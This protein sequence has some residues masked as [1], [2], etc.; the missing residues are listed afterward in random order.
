MSAY[1]KLHGIIHETTAPYCPETNGR[2]ERE[3]KTIKDAARAMLHTYNSP[4][5]LWAEAVAT[6]VYI[7]NRILN[8]MSP[9][10]TAYQRIFDKK[11]NLK[12]AHVFGCKAYLYIPKEQRRVWDM[13]GK[14]LTFVGYEGAKFKLFDPNTKKIIAARNVS[15]CEDGLEDYVKMSIGMRTTKSQVNNCQQESDSEE[16]PFDEL[17]NDSSHEVDEPPPS[18]PST[19]STASS[20]SSSS[21]ASNLSNASSTVMT[22]HTKKGNYTTQIPLNGS[23]TIKIP[24]NGA[25]VL[26]DRQTLSKP[27]LYPDVDSTSTKGKIQKPMANLATIRFEP[28]TYE[29]AINCPDADKWMQAMKN[30]LASHKEHGTWILVD[31]PAKAS[32][33]KCRW[34]FKIKSKTDGT[35]DCYKARLV[36]KGF[37]QKANIDY[38][39]TFASVGRYESIRLLLAIAAAKGMNITQFDIKTA[40]LYGILKEYILMTQPA[41]FEEGGNKL[42]HLLKSIYGLKQGPQCW[43]EAFC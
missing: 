27:A 21:T 14:P 32:P 18:S 16:D 23:S 38:G 9:H 4:E 5:F 28:T 12:N 8:K 20:N 31:K 37:K 36:C 26:R 40:F 29:E 15:F 3:M 11:P 34:V 17:D 7:H 24:L 35:I 42:C 39:E 1:F 43:N 19:S 33:L 22:V 13:K 30:E 10:E 6:S 2:A 25:P 41:G